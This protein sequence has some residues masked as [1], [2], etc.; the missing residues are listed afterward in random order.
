[1][2][3]LSKADHRLI[4]KGLLAQGCTVRESQHNWLFTLP[5]VG[6]VG[7]AKTPSNYRGVLNARS[8]VRRLGLHWPLDGKTRRSQQVH[9]HVHTD[10]PPLPEGDR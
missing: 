8:Q 10:E 3:I 1:M 9:N 5:G 7:I 4:R 6:I 2:S